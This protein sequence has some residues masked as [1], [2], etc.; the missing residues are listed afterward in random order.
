VICLVPPKSHIRALLEFGLRYNRKQTRWE[1]IDYYLCDCDIRD[2]EL[3]ELDQVL[4]GARER[5]AKVRVRGGYF[6][7][8]SED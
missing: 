1:G 2:L 4:A 7:L 5:A 3:W 6:Y 8:R